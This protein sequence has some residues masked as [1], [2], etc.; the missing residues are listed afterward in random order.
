MFFR[1]GKGV[2]LL[3]RA[4]CGF[5]ALAGSSL[6]V[7]EPRSLPDSV[8]RQILILHSYAQGNWWTDDQM[9]GIQE[10]MNAA[11]APVEFF[12]EYMDAQRYARPEYIARL[13][14]TYRYKYGKKSVEVVLATDEPALEFALKYRPDLFPQA[15]IVFSGVQ[16]FDE[17]LTA[18]QRR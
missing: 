7:S 18:G 6:A 2:A 16:N 5:L 1:A 17:T 15:A 11:K 10:R 3:A 4:A 14:E 9:A 8:P 12:V 13:V